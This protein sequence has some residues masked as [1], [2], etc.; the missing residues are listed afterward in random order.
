MNSLKHPGV[1]AGEK[2]RPTTGNL[3]AKKRQEKQQHPQTGVANADEQNPTPPTKHIQKQ[4]QIIPARV[5]TDTQCPFPTPEQE[6]CSQGQEPQPTREEAEPTAWQEQRSQTT[7][8]SSKPRSK[9][10]RTRTGGAEE[11]PPQTWHQLDNIDLKYTVLH[12]VPTMQDVPRSIRG[13]I[14]TAYSIALFHLK[15]TYSNPALQSEANQQR[16]WKLFL[17]LSRMLLRPTPS[18][19]QEGQRA[20]WVRIT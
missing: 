18:K 9:R 1:T 6:R 11:I 4:Q 20:L 14:R 16:A 7:D 17:L 19:G 12:E 2:M 3:R 13:A 15:A 8:S 5:P 10:K